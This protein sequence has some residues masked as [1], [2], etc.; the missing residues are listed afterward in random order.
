MINKLIKNL[1]N[2]NMPW[3]NLIACLS[4]ARVL[5]RAKCHLLAKWLFGEEALQ[6]HCINKINDPAERH[7]CVFPNA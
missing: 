5:G 7:A 3:G 6:L 4:D 1:S 2:L